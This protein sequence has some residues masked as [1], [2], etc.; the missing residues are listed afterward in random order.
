MVATCDTAVELVTLDLPSGAAS[1]QI[2]CGAAEM[3]SFSDDGK[4]LLVTA[5]VHKSR[6]STFVTVTGTLPVF[7]M[8]VVC[9]GPNVPAA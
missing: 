7:V 2:N 5:L 4:S 1:R 6:Y 8:V 9:V 3:V